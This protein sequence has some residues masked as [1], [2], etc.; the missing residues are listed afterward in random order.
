M[1]HNRWFSTAII[2]GAAVSLAAAFSL[3]FVSSAFCLQ[4]PG[5]LPNA[6]AGRVRE[7]LIATARI[8]VGDHYLSGI[9]RDLFNARDFFVGTAMLLFSIVFPFAKLITV[10]GLAIR[11]HRRRLER[12]PWRI[13]MWYIP[14]AN[15]SG[16]T[17]RATT[18]GRTEGKLTCRF[19]V[20][21]P[22]RV[23]GQRSW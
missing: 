18:S 12:W 22:C 3:P 2:I 7:Y 20:G 15:T 10:A 6:I 14:G 9:I 11:G 5:W 23:R 1:Q 4:L 16:T 13:G 21:H 17:R 8:P 19:G